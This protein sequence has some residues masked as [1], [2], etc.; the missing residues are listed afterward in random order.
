MYCFKRTIC[1]LVVFFYSYLSFG[2]NNLPPLTLHDAVFLALRYNPNVQ[3]QQF[4]QIINQFD[5]EVAKNAFELQYALTGTAQISKI[6]TNGTDSTVENYIAAPAVSLE[7]QHGGV[8]SVSVN[9]ENVGNYFFPQIT[10]QFSQPLI[11]G[12]RKNIVL[13][14]LFNAMDQEKIGR[15]QLKNTIVT[16]I[17]QVIDNYYNVV[18]AENN[19]VILQEALQ[20]AQQTLVM[21]Q[22]QIHAGVAPEADLAQ[23]QLNTAQAKLN[24]VLAENNLQQNKQNLL[25]TIG[26][27][28]NT[29]ITIPATI[30][31][32][33]FIIPDLQQSIAIALKNDPTYQADL[34]NLAILKR[35]LLV[36]KDNSLWQLN[37]NVK[38]AWTPG[39]NQNNA[40]A[41]LVNGSSQ[42][43]NLTLNVPL[44]NYQLK[45][46]IVAANVTLKQQE[47]QTN[48]DKHAVI[49]NVINALEQL[50]AA[51]SAIQFSQQ[52][53]QLA[54]TDL[55]NSYTE[56]KFGRTTILTV[57]QQQQTLTS[58]QQAVITNQIAYLNA[59]AN[60]QQVTQTALDY[61]RIAIRY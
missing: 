59:L 44:D 37:A 40:V 52:G 27:D 14:P 5:L 48:F 12:F 15:L 16:I 50:T 55:N 9:E 45:Q 30:I 34:L 22:E 39:N 36:A 13:S 31:V 25:L 3:S 6:H 61:W 32:P 8:A 54:N 51:E 35:N 56:Y 46:Q 57:T 23:A 29:Q 58:A 2:A 41:N 7:T 20:K 49:T 38:S 10:A 19:L 47:I 60:Y 18:A 42:S 4:Q 11:S 17:T 24:I 33:K 28:P 43:A 21:T 1:F 53:Q 26:L